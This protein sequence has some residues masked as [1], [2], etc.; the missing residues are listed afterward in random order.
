MQEDLKLEIRDHGVKKRI[1]DSRRKERLKG[2]HRDP[3]KVILQIP[4]AGN[5]PVLTGIVFPKGASKT[6][7][8]AFF[9]ADCQI[10]K[11]FQI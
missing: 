11:Q 2:N 5:F 9:R 8:T 1:I 7:L 4:M 10:S 3:H 6:R